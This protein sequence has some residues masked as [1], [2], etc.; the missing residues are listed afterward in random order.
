MANVYF[1]L[2]RPTAR[3]YS[4]GTYPQTRFQAQNGATTVVRFTNRRSNSEL[5][6]TFANIPDDQAAQIISTYE[7]TNSGWIRLVFDNA[8]GAVGA[9]NN[10]AEYIREV[11][12]SG[13]QWRFAEPPTVESVKAGI[14][15]VTCRFT[16]FLDGV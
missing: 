9:S 11:N 10:L 4:P 8:N 3:S 1:P 15:T 2:I 16:G 7:S 13:L 5:S 14:S 12:G 6:L